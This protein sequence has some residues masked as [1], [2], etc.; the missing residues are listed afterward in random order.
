MLE[1]W[2]VASRCLYS[3]LGTKA[4]GIMSDVVP[5]EDVHGLL[6]GTLRKGAVLVAVDAVAR[7]GHEVA[8]RR[9]G[10]AQRR[11]VAVVDVRAIELNHR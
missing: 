10:V 4:W 7:D 3:S 5:E 6:E 9:H 1:E 11:Q 2:L 8:T